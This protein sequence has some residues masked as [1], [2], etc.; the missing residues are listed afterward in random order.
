MTNVFDD[1]KSLGIIGK[2]SFGIVYKVEH[3]ISH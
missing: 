2:G 3:K 1:Y